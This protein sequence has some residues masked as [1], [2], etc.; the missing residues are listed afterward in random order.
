[1]LGLGLLLAIMP[2]MSATQFEWVVRDAFNSSN[3]AS[4]TRTRSYVVGQ[5]GRCQDAKTIAIVPRPHA[6]TVEIESH[7]NPNCTDPQDMAIEWLDHCGNE[8]DETTSKATLVTAHSISFA[9]Y[10]DKDC[11]TTPENMSVYPLEVCATTDSMAGSGSFKYL[12]QDDALVMC[13]YSGLACSLDP[14]VCVAQPS[15]DSCTG[16]YKVAMQG[17][18]A[19]LCPNTT[20]T[21]TTTTTRE[22]QVSSAEGACLNIGLLLFS[23]G[24]LAFSNTLFVRA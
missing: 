20:T 24:F 22:V 5:V 4:D 10:T 12:C 2:A 3:C 7:G 14:N 13:Y 17:A 11:E 9:Y 1:M 18:N 21:S 15:L 23:L 16:S 19:G 8:A 6:V